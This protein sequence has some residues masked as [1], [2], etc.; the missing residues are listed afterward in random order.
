MGGCEEGR[1]GGEGV[2]EEGGSCEEGYR[3]RR[4]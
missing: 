4:I 1:V 2:M 3:R